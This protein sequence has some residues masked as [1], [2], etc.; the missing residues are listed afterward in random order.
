MHIDRDGHGDITLSVA[1]GDVDGDG[2]LDLVCGN[3]WG[4]R[5]QRNRLYVNDGTGTFLD[6]SSTHLPEDR[7]STRGLALGD[8]DGDGD[9]DLVC[10]NTG[11]RRRNRMYLNDGAG[12]FRDVTVTHLPR[13]RGYCLFLADVDQ[14]DD[15]DLWTGTGLYLN[16]SR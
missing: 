6:V 2:D 9:L 12:R 4:K 14:D 7:E 13:S 10:M 5:W 16:R 15:L 1:L 3:G 8:V 11:G